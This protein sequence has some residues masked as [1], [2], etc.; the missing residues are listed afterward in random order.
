M[1]NPYNAFDNGTIQ[2]GDGQIATL[3]KR[4][5]MA[6]GLSSVAS[7]DPGAA[8]ATS[9]ALANGTRVNSTAYEAYR[10]CKTSAGVLVSLFGYNSGGAGWIQLFDSATLPADGAFPVATF[11]VPGTANFSL[12]VAV[13]GLP[14]T[15][16]IVAVFSSTGPTKTLGTASVF[17]TGL[18]K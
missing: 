16:G 6:L 11:A 8:P 17:F 14:F 15:T 4:L 7:T 13:L 5:A 2:P 12:D 18:V 3:L 10:I 9:S 1:S